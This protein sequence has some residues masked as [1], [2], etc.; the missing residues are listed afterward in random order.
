MTPPR[1]TLILAPLLAALL[2]TT[3]LAT[4]SHAA[5][6][7]DRIVPACDKPAASAKTALMAHNK[8]CLP[9]APPP[10]PPPPPPPV[11]TSDGP[12]PIA[13]SRQ[14][15]PY[16]VSK[17]GPRGIAVGKA[18]GGLNTSTQFNVRLSDGN[19]Y[20]FTRGTISQWFTLS[21]SDVEVRADNW[22]H[23]DG[24]AVTAVGFVAYPVGA[25]F[26]GM[27]LLDPPILMGEPPVDACPA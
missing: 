9:P 1:R 19:T 16:V 8:H 3:P 25:L 21:W 12:S 11:C 26:G 6:P 10:P 15:G 5:L 7:P 20:G 27:Q 18:D 2:A 4:A 24:K 14:A 22:A 13:T 23:F 17:I